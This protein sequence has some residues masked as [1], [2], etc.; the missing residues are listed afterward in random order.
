MLFRNKPINVLALTGI[1]AALTACEAAPQVSHSAAP[2]GESCVPGAPPPNPPPTAPAPGEPQLEG[3]PLF[4]ADNE[5]NRRVDGAP[6]D[7]RSDQYMAGMSAE[8]RFLHP[9]FGGNGE[10]GIPWVAVPGSQPKVPMIFDYAEDSD[11]GP[12]P[13]PPDAPIEGGSEPWGD[14]HVLVLDRDNCRLYETFD[15]WPHGAGWRAGSGAI[16]DLR[17]N[18]LRPRY[19]TSADAA[20]LPILPGLIRLDEVAAGQIKHALRFTVRR[21]QRAFVH[22]ATHFASPHTDPS[23]PPM[24]LR[25]RLKQDFDISS[26]GQT[27]RVILTAMKEY[28]MFMADNGADWFVTGEANTGWIEEEV[29]ELTR[30]PASAFEVIQHGELTK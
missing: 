17:S 28:G 6:V 16:F 14:R 29:G 22:P 5:W 1:I 18:A 20:G 11:P 10:Y 12:Y 21:T 3:C 2:L 24:G 23:L 26:F 15:T 8:G 9:D 27:A 30:V 19:L 7:P 13:I 4:P 25:V